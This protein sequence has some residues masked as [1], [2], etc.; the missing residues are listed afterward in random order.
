MR[1]STI[2]ILLPVSLL[3]G[4][5]E[6][7]EPAV[8][9]EPELA[10]QPTFRSGDWERFPIVIDGI[11]TGD[12]GY[13]FEIST[14]VFIGLSDFTDVV[15]RW[16]GFQPC[17]RGTQTAEE[18]ALESFGYSSW[19]QGYIGAAAT[20]GVYVILPLPYIATTPYYCTGTLN[21][22]N[23]LNPGY[24]E[25]W[26]STT[27]PV[28]I[29]LKWDT[30]SAGQA[31]GQFNSAFTS[32]WTDKAEYYV[33]EV[34]DYD[35]NNV[36]WGWRVIEEL[37]Y[38]ITVEMEFA[39]AQRDTVNSFDGTRPM[40]SYTP[41][42][43]LPTGSMLWTLLEKVVG[44]ASNPETFTL[45]PADP[46]AREAS[47]GTVV[48][49]Y[50]ENVTFERDGGG[51]MSQMFDHVVTG[52]YI[53]LWFGSNAHENRIFPYH[54]NRL[55]REALDNLAEVYATNA[56]DEV[57]EQDPPEHILFHA[58]GMTGDHAGNTAEFARHDFWVGLHQGK[59]LWI[60]SYAYNDEGEGPV[61]EQ[62][63]RALYLIK[64]EMRPYLASGNDV[65]PS[66]SNDGAVQTSPGDYYIDLT[67]W[68]NLHHLAM[69][70]SPDAEYPLINQ[71]LFR[72]S[73][74]GYLIVTNSYDQVSNVEV[75]F[76]D[77][78]DD[79]EIV[80]GSSAALDFEDETLYD[81]FDGIDGR[82]YKITF[83]TCP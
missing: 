62:Y 40:I 13:E 26:S 37:R 58:P 5:C 64:S 32:Y 67:G 19:T 61:W 39:L 18:N 80:S 4:S 78:I 83:T 49:H 29:P 11:N 20:E 71:T 10:E 63:V 75:D 12:M 1:K 82:V 22:T 68:G 77:C 16:T 2:L 79:V 48:P 52:N 74:I 65:V 28:Q 17:D 27:P 45:D 72:I 24:E 34:D 73:D 55:G 31:K 15:T 54:R 51:Y 38:W 43:Y 59:G 30:G 35:T 36:V 23:G 70:D 33:D 50:S 53:E 69:R 8:E 41:V 66:G 44:G 6:N 14:G 60:Y 57:I 46:V 9:P 3:L 76:E 81:T 21:E 42:A 47:S 7:A 56:E 25:M